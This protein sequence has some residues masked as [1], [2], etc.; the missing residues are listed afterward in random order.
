MNSLHDGEM[1][2]IRVSIDEQYKGEHLHEPEASSY[3]ALNLFGKN[4]QSILNIDR[5]RELF[6]ELET[7]PWDFITLNETWREKR[8]EIW[9]TREG[10]LFLGAEGTKGQRGV[11]IMVHRSHTKGFQAF[12]VISERICALDINIRSAKFRIISVYMTDGSY[13]DATV[14]DAYWDLARL[15]TKSRQLRDA[16]F[17]LVTGTRWLGH[18]G[19]VKNSQL[20]TTEQ[21]PGTNAVN[22]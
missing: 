17:W 15:C 3:L 10:H 5:E 11:A 18:S 19:M 13:D 2:N 7:I 9:T 8:E 22:G 6:E 21:A 16:I 20:A 12:H 14:E 4:V 1:N